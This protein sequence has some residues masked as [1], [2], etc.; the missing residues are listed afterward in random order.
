MNITNKT[1]W[2]M[3]SLV[4]LKSEKNHIRYVAIRTLGKFGNMKDYERLLNLVHNE[5]LELLN[6]I[7]YSIKEIIDRENNDENIKKMEEIYLEKFETMKGLRPKIIM[8]EMSRSFDIQFREQMWVRLLRDSKN[9]LKYTIISVLKDVKDLKVLDE[10]LNSAETTDSLLRR[11]ALETWYSGLMKYDVETIMDY[12]ADKLHFLIRA[13]YELQ[14]DGKLLKQSLSYSDKNAITS[15]KAYPDFMIRY[16]TELLG[17]WDYDPD[18]YRTLHSI[19]VPSYFT[20]SKGE[21][22]EET[23]VQL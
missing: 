4:K 19:M 20:F 17:L 10:V 9:D 12:I 11:I 23:Y 22:E 5:N 7:C 8:I 6:S 13:T 2:R 18:A 3:I 14:T 16:M 1:L 15:P 21:E